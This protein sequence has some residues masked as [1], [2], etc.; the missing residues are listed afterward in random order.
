MLARARLCSCISK[1]PSGP[2]A[3]QR[4][5]RNPPMVEAEPLARSPLLGATAEPAASSAPGP[6]EPDAAATGITWP[7]EEP[8]AHGAGLGDGTAGLR[9]PS[10]LQAADDRATA[11]QLEPAAGRGPAVG[12]QSWPTACQPSGQLREGERLPFQERLQGR[13]QKL[14]AIRAQRQVRDQEAA[15]G[16]VCCFRSYPRPP[17][18]RG[19]RVPRSVERRAALAAV[20]IPPPRPLPT[21]SSGFTGWLASLFMRV[22]CCSVRD[23]EDA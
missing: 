8:Q 19:Q 20:G 11:A 23:P 15:E 5:A 7:A 9:E 3:A 17:H 6:A 4:P 18:G 14:S 22:R 1:H 12:R 13:A 21:E 16:A 10:T 2:E